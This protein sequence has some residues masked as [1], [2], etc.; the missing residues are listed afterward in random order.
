MFAGSP[1]YA[2]DEY[3]Q[4]Y[5]YRAGISI[6]FSC[7]WYEN[8]K[9]ASEQFTCNERNDWGCNK[10]YSNLFTIELF[11]VYETIFSFMKGTAYS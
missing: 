11:F 4:C 5:T 10:P 2:P 7:T 1:G 3:I 8:K 9:N 6:D